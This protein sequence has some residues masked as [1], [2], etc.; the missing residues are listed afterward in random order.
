MN[1]HTG[2]NSGALQ[3]RVALITGAGGGIG[4]A[5]A[6]AFAGA[7]ARVM[8]ANRT[9]AAAEAV[10]AG[11]RAAGREAQAVDFEASEASCRAAVAATAQ[12]YGALDIVVHNAGGCRWAR[13]E[14]LSADVLDD[15]L[16]LNLKCCFWLTQ[17]ALPQLRGR[18]GARILITSSVTGP[19]SAMVGAAHYAAAKAGVNGFI[20]SAALELAPLHITVNGVE[21]GFIAKDRGRLSEPQTR[22][23]IERYI[24]LGA[25]GE[26][27]DIAQAMLY[28]AGDGAR[29]M[30]GQTL[31]VDGGAMLPES[32][33]AM[34][35]QWPGAAS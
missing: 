13:I 2:Q 18:Q 29:W 31:I 23:R 7:G 16:T 26:A 9:R 27:E 32:G 11:L 5:I 25:M 34:E 4:A 14:E 28:L 35:S 6:A 33:Y 1:S 10:A 12:A 22:A 21:P 19:R 24:P 17:A 15:A 8:L 30:T 3:G 20:R